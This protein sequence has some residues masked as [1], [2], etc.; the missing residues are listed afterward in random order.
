MC[1]LVQCILDLSL[2]ESTVHF[3]AHTQLSTE[4]PYSAL[5][6]SV[7]TASF[8]FYQT[9]KSLPPDLISV[10][11][12]EDL[13]LIGQ[14]FIPVTIVEIERL[15]VSFDMEAWRNWF[16]HQYLDF[17]PLASTFILNDDQ[18]SNLTNSYFG[19]TLYRL[20]PLANA[21]LK[22]RQFI[23]HLNVVNAKNISAVCHF[24]ECE[25][26]QADLK[27]KQPHDLEIVEFY[28]DFSYKLD[29]SAEERMLHSL[30]E[31][32]SPVHLE[33]ILRDMLVDEA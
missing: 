9:L 16:A 25:R 30:A 33:V 20:Q 2:N 13:K 7:S 6:Q 32:L 18:A 17:K 14:A 22:I 23:E 28:R 27:K 31:D 10:V 24:N 1:K 21:T 19:Q 3:T 4:G 11:L 15:A 29:Q 12:N 26:K 5:Q 8:E